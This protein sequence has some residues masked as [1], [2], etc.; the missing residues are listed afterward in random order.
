MP[1]LH[2]QELSNG[3]YVHIDPA[4]AIVLSADRAAGT[5]KH[6]IA[7]EPHTFLALLRYANSVGWGKVILRAAQEVKD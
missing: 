3:L 7:L 2:K 1:E 5:V 6:W 4:Q